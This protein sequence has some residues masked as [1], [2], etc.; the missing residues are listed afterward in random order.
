MANEYPY[1]SARKSAREPGSEPT[2]V[3]DGDAVCQTACQRRAQGRTDHGVD[4]QCA[5]GA[6][7]E[8]SSE[9][10]C[11][12][13]G[14]SDPSTDDEYNCDRCYQPYSNSGAIHEPEC[15]CEA[16]DEP[17]RKA[18]QRSR[19]RAVDF[20]P[21]EVSCSIVA[22]RSRARKSATARPGPQSIC[23]VVLIL[24]AVGRRQG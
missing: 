24:H 23:G 5:C 15:A 4:R 16:C 21:V 6:A 14:G 9:P 8:P 12:S 10:S 11:E 19:C 7:D 20:P 13:S 1:K 18:C 22:R 3:P 2:Q 17:D